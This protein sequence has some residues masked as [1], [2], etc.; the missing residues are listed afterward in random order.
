MADLKRAPTFLLLAPFQVVALLH[1]SEQV[2]ALAA[3]FAAGVTLM[4]KAPKSS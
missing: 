2:S 4:P 1:I 3:G